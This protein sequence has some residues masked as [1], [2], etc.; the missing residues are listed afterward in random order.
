MTNLQNTDQ[1][2][3]DDEELLKFI[4]EEEGKKKI[5]IVGSGGSGTNTLDRVFEMGIAGVNLIGMN[6]DARHLLKIKAHK[7][8]S[9]WKENYRRKRCRFQSSDRRGVCKRIF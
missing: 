7:K 1:I 6:T 9:S 8:N 5:Y 3:K 4:Q 2:S